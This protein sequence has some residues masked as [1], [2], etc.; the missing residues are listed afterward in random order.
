MGRRGRVLRHRRRRVDP[1]RA[2]APSHTAYPSPSAAKD[3]PDTRTYP[4]CPGPPAE[5]G[6]QFTTH[7]VYVAPGDGPVHKLFVVGHGARESIEVFEV[8]TSAD[9]SAAS[10]GSAAW[11]R[12]SRSV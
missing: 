11:S 5:G 1:R 2:I 12:P 7:G 8:D 9:D 6:A 10:R 4:E 3:R